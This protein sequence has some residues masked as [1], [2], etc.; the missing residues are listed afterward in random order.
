M[1]NLATVLYSRWGVRQTEG[2]TYCRLPRT[3]SW[4]SWWAESAV[5]QWCTLLFEDLLAI[6][7]N[8][9]AILCTHSLYYVWGTNLGIWS[10]AAPS[11]INMSNNEWACCECNCV[12]ISANGITNNLGTY[13]C[14]NVLAYPTVCIIRNTWYIRAHTHQQFFWLM[15]LC[16][17]S[18]CGGLHTVCMEHVSCYSHGY[19]LS[20]CLL[21]SEN[22]NFH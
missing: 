8:N 19:R 15:R 16:Q 9:N 14:M 22:V 21:F 1:P 4:L 6:V 20:W 2:G 12:Y 11:T 13:V 7:N 17:P 10:R 3:W 5:T 18:Y